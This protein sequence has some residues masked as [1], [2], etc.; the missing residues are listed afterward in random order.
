MR[1]N[2][3]RVPTTASPV[4]VRV[5]RRPA[6]PGEPVRRDA[7]DLLVS[8]V[9]LLTIGGLAFVALVQGMIAL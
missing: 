9:V 7:L 3:E 6:T 5:L 2:V 4:A 1:R 8:I